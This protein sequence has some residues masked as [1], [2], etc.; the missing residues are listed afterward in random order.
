MGD[1]M[2]AIHN[3]M[4]KGF[5]L[6]EL[7]IVVFILGVVAAVIV[8]NFSAFMKGNRIKMSVKSVIVAGKYAK[9][10]AVL[11]QK[12]T[13]LFFDF[14]SNKIYVDFASA[15]TVVEDPF[16]DEV[17]PDFEENDEGG[18]ERIVSTQNLNSAAVEHLHGIDAVERTLEDGI[19]FESVAV[20]VSEEFSEIDNIYREGVC[21]VVYYT[22]GRCEPYI[23][24][25]GLDSDSSELVTISVDA[26]GFV[27]TTYD[28]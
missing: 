8:P 25:L 10:V 23:V 2:L 17:L 7:M 28:E 11:R 24:T 14:D 18:F 15:A 26:L 20:N 9:S 16:A 22:N 12:D 13:A 27:E 3:N 6:I 4:K 1:P 19:V 21:Q 5:T